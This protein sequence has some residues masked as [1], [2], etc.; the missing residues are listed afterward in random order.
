MNFNPEEIN[1]LVR[2]RRSVYPKDY[3]GAIVPDSVIEQML[4]NANW[5]PNHKLTEPWRFVVFTGTGLKAL[6][7]FQSECYKQVTSANGT[8]RRPPLCLANQAYGIFP[9][10]CRWYET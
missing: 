3:T 10:H 6:A 2:Q 9:R 1:E 8:F 5:A 4:E 7:A